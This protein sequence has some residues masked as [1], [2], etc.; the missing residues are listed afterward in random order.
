[1]KKRLRL[2]FL[3]IMSCCFFA[4]VYWVTYRYTYEDLQNN[5]LYD[6]NQ[7]LPAETT[8]EYTS[9]LKQIEN[10]RDEREII[11]AKTA[12]ILEKYD[13]MSG[14]LTKEI[15]PM[16]IELLGL[17]YNGIYGYVQGKSEEDE[18]GRTELVAFQHDLLVLRKTYESKRPPCE[19]Q[20]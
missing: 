2:I 19:K 13:E 6:E 16:P 8:K 20:E 17:D 4:F 1:M 5:K 18:N 10:E 7:L 9:A 14:E 3:I 11:T 15:I 12:Y